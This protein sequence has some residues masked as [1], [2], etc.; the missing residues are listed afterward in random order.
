[1]SLNFLLLASDGLFD[2]VCNDKVISFVSE[3]LMKGNS[4][5][6]VL[7][8]LVNQATK[9]TEDDVIVACIMLNAG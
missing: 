2:V 6:S 9:L 4:L 8:T 3:S 5:S 1:M 7:K